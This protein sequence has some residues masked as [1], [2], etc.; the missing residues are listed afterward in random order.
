[1]RYALFKL[2]G[3]ATHG[4]RLRQTQQ[5]V[6]KCRQWGLVLLQGMVWSERIKGSK[7][8]NKSWKSSRILKETHLKG[9]SESRRRATDQ[10]RDVWTEKEWYAHHK[11]H[12]KEKRVRDK[13]VKISWKVKPK[14]SELGNTQRV[15]EAILLWECRGKASTL[16]SYWSQIRGKRASQF[17]H[18]GINRQ[19]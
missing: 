5:Q 11:S 19:N 2:L 10:A 14:P 15:W 18:F 17:L 6:N 12:W 1:M 9:L 8:K 4:T 3:N 7:K 13:R 16:S